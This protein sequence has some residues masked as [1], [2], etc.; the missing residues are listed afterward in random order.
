MHLA[1]ERD[2]VH[3]GHTHVDESEVGRPRLHEI[4]RVKCGL[5]ERFPRAS[6]RVRARSTLAVRA[7]VLADPGALPDYLAGDP[8]LRLLAPAE[9]RREAFV[10]YHRALAGSARVR[11]VGQ[12]LAESLKTRLT[13]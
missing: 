10:V 7:A 12:F 2:T 4:E 6:I 1:L 9:V 3:D 8:R 5:R 11:A 13:A